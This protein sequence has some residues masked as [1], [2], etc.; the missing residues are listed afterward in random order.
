MFDFE[1]LHVYQTVKSL[2]VKVFTFLKKSGGI[3]KNIA[4]QWQRASL[5][6]LLNLAEGTGRVSI[7]DKRHLYTIARGSIYE[8]VAILDLVH[9]LGLIESSRYEEMYHEYEEASKMLLALHRSTS[10][11]S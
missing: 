3:D 10:K 2:N 9:E 7:N 6:V 11:S 5:S 4:D 1:K 8:C